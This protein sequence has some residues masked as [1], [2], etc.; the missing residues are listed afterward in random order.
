MLIIVRVIFLHLSNLICSVFL[1]V[2][3]RDDLR[4]EVTPTITL[5]STS[6]PV[7]TPVAVTARVLYS[8]KIKG[9]AMIRDKFPSKIINTEE[10]PFLKSVF[11]E[12]AKVN[13]ISRILKSPTAII[14]VQKS[15]KSNYEIAEYNS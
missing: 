1:K 8:N 11:E 15:A 4:I 2:T 3:S 9:V 7:G 5:N 10:N 6:G 13:F 12:R 14:L